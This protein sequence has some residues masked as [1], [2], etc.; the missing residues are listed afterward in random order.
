MPVREG[1]QVKLLRRRGEK[2]ES[3][4][5]SDRFTAREKAHALHVLS[6]SVVLVRH[7][8]DR[9]PASGS[10]NCWCGRHAGASL[11][12]VILEP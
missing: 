1:G 4:W 3:A 8:Y 9:D 5:V 11:H 7:P 2:I 10:G 12:D 6:G